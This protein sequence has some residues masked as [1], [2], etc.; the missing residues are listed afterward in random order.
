M[1]NIIITS[2]LLINC[3]INPFYFTQSSCEESY[4]IEI[5]SHIDP[6][7]G[8]FDI[9][10]IN[11]LSANETLHIDFDDSFIMEDAYGKNDIYGGLSNNHL[12]I[13]QG[14][15]SR[16][17]ITVDIEG[18]PAGDWHGHIGLSVSLHRQEP[19][20][21][22]IDGQSLNQV[23]SELDPRTIT[24]TKG[25]P[26][27]EP[28]CDVSM[29]QDGS[30]VLHVYGHDVIIATCDDN[31]VVFNDDMSMAFKD[32]R[33]LETVDFLNAVDSGQ[34]AYASSLFEN[35]TR[36]SSIN[37]IAGLDASSCEDMSK[38]FKSCES[39]EYLD[40]SLW[41]TDRCND[42]S[43][44]CYFMDE[45]VSPGDLSSWSIANVHDISGM[46]EGCDSL[47]DI[48]DISGWDTSSCN[49]M[50]R[51]F[52]YCGMLEDIGDISSWDVEANISFSSMFEGAGLLS[53]G[54]VQNWNVSD[55]AN[56]LSHMFDNAVVPSSMNLCNWDVSNVV[57][58]SGMFKNCSSLQSLDISSWDT[59]NLA[60][61]SMMFSIDKTGVRSS[62]QSIYGLSNLKTSSLLDISYMFY[63]CSNLSSTGY[64]LWDVSRIL[65]MSY[66]FYAGYY[67]DL[68]CF[69][70]WIINPSCNYS[71]AFG[72][73]AGLRSGTS[74]PSWYS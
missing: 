67:F 28:Y 26:N 19:S 56:D 6:S 53:L 11:N 40:L 42:M 14:D 74:A 51:L 17:T 22:I 47:N 72:G 35:C 34:M 60:D 9:E 66:A 41:Q 68:T 71:E 45:L 5:P 70:N 25:Y 50:S 29:A 10:I 16:H 39:I 12:E 54:D 21:V 58:M 2:L 37:G 24:F 30:V 36:L 7:E 32:L 63:K 46:F 38:M 73:R 65:D 64:E 15:N 57:N 23:L 52:Y 61:A 43:M 1:K 44:M 8:S 48:G 33:N 18:M 3:F 69:D 62:L 20:Y 13:T 55:K 49:D 4:T 59:G 31:K 27:I